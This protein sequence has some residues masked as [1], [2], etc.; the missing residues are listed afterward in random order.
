MSSSKK[1]ESGKSSDKSN[2]SY[3]S[4]PFFDTDTS[5]FF[6]G[7]GKQGTAMSFGLLVVSMVLSIV[8]LQYAPSHIHLSTWNDGCPNGYEDSCKAN[9]AVFRFS[10]ALT[11]MFVLQALGS[12]VHP[13]FY[14]VFWVPKIIAFICVVI[15]FYFASSSIFGLGGYAW[16][17]RITGF[18]Y[19]IL[20]QIILL[21]VAYSWNERWVAYSCD[22]GEMGSRWLRGLLMIST[23]LFVG[24]LVVIALLYWQFDGC[25]ENVGIITIT[26]VLPALATIYQVFFSE[27]GSL[28][29]SAIM[30]AYCTYICYSSV[31][32]NP[33]AS[34]NPTIS[35]GYQTI[36]KV[37]QCVQ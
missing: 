33:D 15:G 20:Q 2:A 26:L 30:F 1:S 8:M 36:S 27:E 16:V 13:K 4:V 17:A 12:A 37:T 35:S 6:L 18:L 3:T 19:L 11:I 21:D 32:L 10:F 23:T 7:I 22:D 9:S 25:P 5:E 28:L 34:C 24:S 14:D 31:T 29:V